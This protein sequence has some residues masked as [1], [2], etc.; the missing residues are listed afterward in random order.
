MGSSGSGKTTL[1]HALA[2]RGTTETAQKA[3][4]FNGKS[5]TEF[6]KNGS[7]GFVQQIDYLIPY[8]TVRE[9]LRYTAELRLDRSL[10]KKSKNEMVENVINELGLKECSDTIIGDDWKRV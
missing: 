10:D 3:V 1:L 7:V 5:P 9:T 8:L 2:G 6:Y 4:R